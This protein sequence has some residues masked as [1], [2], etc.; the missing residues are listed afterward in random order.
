VTDQDI[1]EAALPELLAATG[2]RLVAINPATDLETA[3]LEVTT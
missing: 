2:S 1:A 3:F